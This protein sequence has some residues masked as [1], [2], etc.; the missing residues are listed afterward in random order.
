MPLA[1]TVLNIAL[2]ELPEREGKANALLLLAVLFSN[3]AA[4]IESFFYF[5]VL[6]LPLDGI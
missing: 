2:Q 1:I 6:D 3:G 4:G 5:L